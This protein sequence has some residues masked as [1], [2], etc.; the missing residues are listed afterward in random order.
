MSKKTNAAAVPAIDGAFLAMIQNHRHGEALSDLA[1]AMR[2]VTLAVASTGESGAILFKLK[3]KRAAKGG[4]LLVEDEI[5]TTIPKSETPGSIFF[6]DDKGNLLREDPNQQKL[7]LR[8]I[9]GGAPSEE[10]QSLRKA[11]EMNE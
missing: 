5:K 4:A 7:P 8:A 11:M 1:A 6:G 9:S 3:I 10:T 2:E